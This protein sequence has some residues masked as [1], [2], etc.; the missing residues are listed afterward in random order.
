MTSSSQHATT[1]SNVEDAAAAAAPGDASYTGRY[2]ME[3]IDQH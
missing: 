2:E 1:A 3:F